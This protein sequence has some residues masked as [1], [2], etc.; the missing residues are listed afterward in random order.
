MTVT[1]ADLYYDTFKT[2]T[3]VVRVR[4]H[5]KKGVAITFESKE[6]CALATGQPNW[7]SDTACFPG[8]TIQSVE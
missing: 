5:E 8:Y 4:R 1:I 7:E 2:F 6:A 3:K